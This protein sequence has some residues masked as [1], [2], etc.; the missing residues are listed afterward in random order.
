MNRRFATVLLIVSLVVI[1]QQSQSAAGT[2]QKVETVSLSDIQSG[3][4]NFKG[5]IQQAAEVFDSDGNE[6]PPKEPLF[7]Q[8]GTRTYTAFEKHPKL[9]SSLR[10]LNPK[11]DPDAMGTSDLGSIATFSGRT[12]LL[13]KGCFPH[14]CG[15]TEQ[16]VAFEP[17]SNKVYLLQPTNLGPATTPSGRFYLYG[18]PDGSVRGAM[19]SAYIQ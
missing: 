19:Y 8:Y 14:N 3:A 13:L 17:S 5:R 6:A 10:K 7:R 9:V 1:N 15:G 12:L 2:T 4:A 16:I 11:F 18:N